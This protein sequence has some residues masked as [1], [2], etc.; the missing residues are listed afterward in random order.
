MF[1]ADDGDPM[2]ATEVK[3]ALERAIDRARSMSTS[4]PPG[5]GTTPP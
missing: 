1:K 4:R 5:D 2:S 3:L